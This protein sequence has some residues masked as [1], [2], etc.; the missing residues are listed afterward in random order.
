MAVV[1]TR[2][3]FGLTGPPA[4]IRSQ[5]G[6]VEDRTALFAGAEDEIEC[7][8]IKAANTQHTADLDF[9]SD[10]EVLPGA[11]SV[12]VATDDS[13][14]RCGRFTVAGDPTFATSTAERVADGGVLKRALC[15]GT[16]LAILDE[17]SGT[18]DAACNQRAIFNRGAS[19]VTIAGATWTTVAVILARTSGDQ[20]AVERTSG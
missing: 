8:E 2:A 19:E 10:V 15:V 7:V 6:A 17:G 4:A 11:E 18:A 20:S 5:I 16:A 3:R 14:R 9:D 12:V 13:A 1:G